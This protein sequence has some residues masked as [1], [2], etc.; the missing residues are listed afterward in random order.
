MKIKSFNLLVFLYGITIN[1]QIQQNDTSICAGSSIS[2]NASETSIFESCTGV[3]P[4]NFTSWTPI[5]PQGQYFNIIKEEGIYYLRSN[6]DVFKSDSLNGPWTSMNFSSQIGNN[7]AARMFGF[8]WENKLFVSTCNNDLYAYDNGTWV[9]KGLG[10]YGCGGNFIQKLANNRII[11]M[12]SGYLRD[13]YISDNNGVSWANVTN[14]D[15]DYWDMVISDNGTIFSCGGYNTFP[16]TGLIKSTN[17]GSSFT[18]VN[19]QLGISFC[20]GIAKDCN[21]NVYAVGD[22]KIFKTVDNG[23]T[24]IT[25]CNIPPFFEFFPRFSHLIF[26]SNGDIYFWGA[27]DYIT[28][29][30]CGFF[31]SEDNGLSWNQITDLP[32]SNPLNI[33]KIKEIDGNIIVTTTEG[34]FAKT[35]TVNY[36]YLWSTG[37][38][39]PNITVQPTNTTT[40]TLQTS[41]NNLI[42]YDTITVT[43]LNHSTSTLNETAMG[44]YIL[45]GQTYTQSGTYTQIIP[46]SNGCDSV[47]TLNLTLNLAELEQEENTIFTIYPNPASEQITIKI[48]EM[49]IGKSY[50]IHDQ[51]GK[52]IL[53]DDLTEI[54]T[55][56]SLNGFADGVYSIQIE[57]QRKRTFIINKQ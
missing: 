39:T 41:T 22:N 55:S 37:E 50:Q 53:K 30:Q 27:W 24:W 7:C 2:L 44:L 12:K 1:A 25:H 5:T 29:T 18:S 36:S 54:N 3:S 6:N 34:V 14:I 45:N 8:D 28:N 16:M 19:N 33:M 31:K 21:N 35:L 49:F 47:I 42:T 43:L 4:V 38:T 52:L 40:Y 32:I 10:G 17:N 15:N 48:D 57:N 23:D 13:L 26:A 20:S 9:A 56:L 11:A 46:A 51:V